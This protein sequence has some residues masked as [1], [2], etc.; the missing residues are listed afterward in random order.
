MAD[1]INAFNESVSS[2]SNFEKFGHFL[3]S[4][5]KNIGYDYSS[6]KSTVVGLR[7]E[8]DNTK[9][10]NQ[11]VNDFLR[12][13]QSNAIRA[14]Y[15]S[16]RP[17]SSDDDIFGIS[18][19]KV[20]D[21]FIELESPAKLEISTASKIARLTGEEPLSDKDKYFERIANK[22]GGNYDSRILI[23]SESKLHREFP[24]L[25]L[26][27]DLRVTNFEV[28]IGDLSGYKLY[29]LEDL[30]KYLQANSRG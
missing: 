16:G 11:S 24:N 8:Y 6:F 9:P 7:W 26:E 10:D 30:G 12:T 3:E 25:Q 19:G 21:F 22:L 27:N 18:Q 28:P 5:S 14:I 4:N 15:S 1:K 13:C 29:A 2:S 17:I 23:A 20:T